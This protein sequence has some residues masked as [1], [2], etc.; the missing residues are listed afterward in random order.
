MKTADYGKIK[1]TVPGDNPILTPP[2]LSPV[3]ADP[4]VLLPE[5]SPDGLWHLFAHTI[6]GVHHFRSD[7]GISWRD[8]VLLIRNAMRA[9]IFRGDDAYYLLYEKYRPLQILVPWMRFWKWRSR[10]EIRA[11][12]DLS[13]W[14]DPAVLLAPSLPWHRD[15]ALGESVS[16]PCLV[17]TGRG[18]LLFFSASLSYVPDCGFCEP[19]HIGMAESESPAGPFRVHPEPVISPDPESRWMNLG[20]GAIKVLR[21]DDGFVGFQNGIYIDRGSGRS[22]S[23]ILLRRSGNGMDW[24]THIEEPVIKPTAGWQR[25]HVYACDIRYHRPGRRF[26]LYYNARDDWHW[27][28]GK[29]S[30]GLITGRR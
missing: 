23:A 24:N 18:Y 25:S 12:R 26:L 14:D 28:R 27:T 20:A 6:W 8:P 15:R 4:S 11:S 16:N 22:G 10:I 2:G 21:A 9:F 7:D 17:R 30:I 19:K 5:E 3:I 1:W 29:E 13:S